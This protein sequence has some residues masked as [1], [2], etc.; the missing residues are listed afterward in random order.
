[1]ILFVIYLVV[2]FGEYLR[3][4]EEYRENLYNDFPYHERFYLELSIIA[5]CL[6][7]G[8]TLLLMKA[9]F[10][11]KQFFRN[12]WVKITLLISAESNGCSDTL[13]YKYMD[14]SAHGKD[15]SA[16]NVDIGCWFGY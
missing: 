10:K 11:M 2:G 1:M 8:P 3:V 9:Y 4:S 6:I 15:S 12:L 13:H 5:V 7:F 16:Y 14:I